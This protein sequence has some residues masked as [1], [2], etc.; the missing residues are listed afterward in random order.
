MKKLKESRKEKRETTNMKSAAHA[1][2]IKHVK[3][4]HRKYVEEWDN[5][6][7]SDDSVIDIIKACHGIAQISV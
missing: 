4:Q 6:N 2:Y 3:E 5:P 7:A 1:A